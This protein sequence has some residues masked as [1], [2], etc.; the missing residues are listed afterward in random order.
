MKV[1]YINLDHRTDRRGKMERMLHGLNVDYERV[2]A[3]Y[4]ELDDLFN[5]GGPYTHILQRYKLTQFIQN[6]RCHERV[7]GVIGCYM[8]HQRVYEKALESDHGDFLILEDDVSFRKEILNIVQ[9][10]KIYLRNHDW[11]MYRCIWR[12]QKING[13]SPNH[14]PNPYKVDTNHELSAFKDNTTKN[15]NWYGGSHFTYVNREKVKK[16]LN[17]LNKENIFAFDAVLNTTELNVFLD[18][19]PIKVETPGSKDIPKTT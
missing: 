8:S 17:Y 12:R 10:K 11:D 16:I 7:R 2:P 19:L 18:Y 3:V 15:N 13:K 1:Y 5:I 4:Y 9:N 14:Y 6:K